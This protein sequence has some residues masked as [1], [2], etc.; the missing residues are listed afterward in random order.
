MTDEVVIELSKKKVLLLIV[1]SIAFVVLG[2]WMFSLDA[3]SIARNLPR[4]DPRFVHGV[5]VAAI[6]FFGLCG[7]IGLRKLFDKKP[8]LVL[9]SSGI[10][11]NSSG[12][13]A[14]FI[15]WSE[16]ED[17][18]I[19]QVGAQK[20]L[21]IMVENPEAYVGRGNIL[22]R[23]ANKMNFKLYGTPILITSNTLKIGF[24]ELLSLFHQYL[25][26]SGHAGTVPGALADSGR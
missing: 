6:V 2:L 21:I 4:K 26:A 18:T 17:A 19:L 23:A 5:G 25:Q 3:S 22:Q 10:T 20:I 15:P 14:G 7:S 16:I 13:S 8:G 11:D 1:G 24:P 9:N 12:L